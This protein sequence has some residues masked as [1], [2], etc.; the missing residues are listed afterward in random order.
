[1]TAMGMRRVRTKPAEAPSLDRSDWTAFGIWGV[2]YKDAMKSAADMR[3]A[4]AK[5]LEAIDK[6]L[7][8]GEVEYLSVAPGSVTRP[9][10]DVLQD[11]RGWFSGELE[12][13]CRALG[14]DS[15]EVG[16]KAA[17]YEY[18]HGYPRRQAEIMALREFLQRFGRYEG[19]AKSVVEGGL[20]LDMAR[21]FLDER[22]LARLCRYYDDNGEEIG[23]EP[24]ILRHTKP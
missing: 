10:V 9:A 16:E 3:R 1:M 8:M 15:G 11:I 24:S 21:R 14:L 20:I 18:D 2:K 22:E 7:G 17:I 19:N 12:M 5:R 23:A 13:A 4:T 6:F